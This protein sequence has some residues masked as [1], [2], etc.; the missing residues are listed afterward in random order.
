MS[1][2]FTR[3]VLVIAICAAVTILERFLPFLIFRQ[4]QIPPMVSYLGKVLPMAIM[5]TLVVY[6]LRGITFTTVAGFAPMLL[7]V[8]LVVGLHLWK[9]NTL[10]SILG[11]T[12]LY[13]FLVQVVFV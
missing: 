13:M 4:R 8:A 5:V 11:G 2:A 12:A 7:A 10:L 1:M 9:G 6:C 3:G